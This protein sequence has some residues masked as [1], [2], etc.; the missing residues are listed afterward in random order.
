MWKTPCWTITG[1]IIEW[2]HQRST[3][4]LLCLIMWLF[5]ILGEVWLIQ[6][7]TSAY[8]VKH[9]LHIT[10]LDQVIGYGSLMD[11]VWVLIQTTAIQETYQRLRVRLKIVWFSSHRVFSARGKGEQD[12]TMMTELKKW[13]GVGIMLKAM[14]RSE[15]N[16][17]VVEECASNTN[18]RLTK[19]TNAWILRRHWWI[20]SEKARRWCRFLKGKWYLVEEC[21][22]GLHLWSN[23][24]WVSAKS[25]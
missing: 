8:L 18:D 23:N 9:L 19:T 11:D 4:G 6:H 2:F 17:R 10:S 20:Q 3:V 7:C 25:E 5:L 1:L 12:L 13:D 22:L 21:R 24:F 15:R 16:R 14:S